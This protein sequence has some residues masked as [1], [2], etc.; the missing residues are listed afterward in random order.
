ME[1]WK[2]VLN[3]EGL[4]LISSHGRVASIKKEIIM[5][6]SPHVGTGYLKISLKKDKYKTFLVHRLVLQSFRCE[7][8]LV[9]NHING[10]KTD[11]NLSNLEFCTQKQNINHSISKLGNCRKGIRN[12]Q[13]LLNENQVKDII[14]LLRKKTKLVDIAKLYKVS[15]VTIGDI[16]Q[17]RSWKHID[18]MTT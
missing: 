13:A 4:Y 11:N 3:Y 15:P 7:S 6:L 5:K 1:I 18:R 17:N 8:S 10:I 9:C 16:K 14:K 2:D 12:S